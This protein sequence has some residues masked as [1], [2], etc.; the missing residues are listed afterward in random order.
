M[1]GLSIHDMQDGGLA[2]DLQE[3]LE[4]L[5]APACEAWWRARPRVWY[6]TEENSPVPALYS[7]ERPGPW[8]RGTDLLEASA[9]VRQVI[10]G[11]LESVQGE[12]PASDGALTPWVVVRAVDSSWW[13]VYSADEDAL[14]RV[15]ARFRDIRAPVLTSD[16]PSTDY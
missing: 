10:D 15:R 7:E 1:K 12:P 16:D 8:T 3:V 2:F 9:H 6:V 13:E 14:R 4:A 11:V 5:G